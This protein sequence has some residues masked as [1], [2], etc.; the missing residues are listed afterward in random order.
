MCNIKLIL[1]TQNIMKF[2]QRK[3]MKK[4]LLIVGLGLITAWLG[5]QNIVNLAEQL[6]LNPKVRYGKLNNGLTYY[7]QHNEEPK[8][9]ASFYIV[10]NVGA[11][12][13]NDKQNGLAHFLEHMAFNGTENFPDKG[14][15]KY[16]EA[17]GVTFGRN[18]NAYTSV[19]ETVYNLSNVPTTNENLID[20][21]LLILHDWSHYLTLAGE[22][23]DKERGVIR[24]ESRTRRSQGGYRIYIGTRKYL[25]EGSKYVERD[26]L[27]DINV[28]DSFDHQEI[29]DFY[30]DYYRTDLQAIVVVGDIDAEAVEKKIKER[31][32][33]I[34][35]VENPKPREYF[36]V[37]GN[38]E[39]IVGVITD[40]EASN[41]RFSLYF[42]HQATAFGDK[43]TGYYRDQLLQQLYSMM[44]G[45]R[46]SELVQTGNPPFISAYA[47]YYN[48][49]RLMDVYNVGAGL[50][51]DNIL[52]G[53]EATMTENERVLRHG[54]ALT[55]LERAKIS[56]LSEFE[57]KYKER[58]KQNNDEIVR[59]LQQ[60]YLVNEPVP[61]IEFEFDLAKKLL[62]EVTLEQIN[63]LA[64]KWN[65]KENLVVTLSGPEKEGLVYPTKEQ[66]LGVLAKVKQ[67]D[68]A[69]YEDKVMDQPLV[70]EMPK[71]GKVIIDKKLSDFDATEWELENGAKVIIKNTDFK[72]NEIL[73]EAYSNGGSS[74]YDAVDLPSVQ[75]LG[76]FMGAF[77]VG[78]FDNVSL[79][80]MLTG[81]VVS[82]SPFLSDLYEGFSGSS[83][84]QDFEILLQ[85]LYLQFEN[86][87][88]DE[89]AFSALKARYMAYVANMDADVNKAFSDSVSLIVTDYN[90]RT[91][92]FNTKMIENLNFS[93][94][95]RIYRDRFVDASD[96][97]FVIV[98]NIKA[99][100]IKP[101]I[102]TYIGG[103]KSTKRIETWKDTEVNS[104]KKDTY[105]AFKKEMKTPK[106][107][108]YIKMHGNELKYNAENRI[109]LDVVSKLLDKRYIDVIRED[110]GGTYGVRVGSAVSLYP[111]EEYA[112]TIS[113][114]TDPE[115]ADKL[116]G[117]IYAEID[118]LIVEGVK[119]DDLEEA[120]KNIIKVREEN[121]RQNNF[122]LG[123]LT[124]YYK[125]NETLVIPA[126]VEDIV[127]GITPEKVQNFAKSY[128][129]KTGKIE[130]VMSPDEM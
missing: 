45:M 52:G 82:I 31:F 22:E 122:W 1:A 129:S 57:K 130:V 67:L 32:S 81:K 78:E 47:A 43:N 105:K 85:L 62:P 125:Y 107:T 116:K 72:E 74:L 54:F 61:G 73:L 127:I 123:A 5:A 104:P 34:Q 126:A 110:E 112:L 16:L 68:V 46:Y 118:K 14:I 91:V 49:V 98:G 33:H 59:E 96:F 17:Y 44:I 99:D 95:E 9:R 35:A 119:T 37:P 111:K 102:E 109:Y 48:N 64:G 66:I 25:Y 56:L 60:N 114:D 101:L 42:K 93:V 19:D 40:P 89:D 80:K 69:A 97:T 94:M 24:E 3:N 53:I 90:K 21:T 121:L 15:L 108:I 36:D 39:P 13:E 83:S 51:E 113:F 65:T 10:Q 26:V 100:E 7:V 27:G 79:E 28:V 106:T 63:A 75:M 12:L 50:K 29:R 117:M 58:N 41:T 4:I 55:E 76:N 86:P 2:K 71:A 87:R 6:P 115:K 84:V 38:K 20:S 128:L 103:I 8:D 120:K 18:I 92:L 77:G 23:I 30:H 11:I 88:F 70:A 124:H